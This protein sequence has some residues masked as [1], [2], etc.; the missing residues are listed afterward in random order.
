MAEIPG[1]VR[2]TGFIAPT[3]STDTYP[4]TDPK[5]GLGGLRRVSGTT[6]RD[7]ISTARRESGMLVFSEAEDTYYKLGTGLTNSD[8]SVFAQG[9]TTS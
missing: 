7:A 8:W 1:S 2:F 3:D 4:V 6:E 9:T 5:W